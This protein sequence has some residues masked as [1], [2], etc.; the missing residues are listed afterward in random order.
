LVKFPISLAKAL[1]G[2]KASQAKAR[3]AVG[4][5][6]QDHDLVFC[7][8]IGTPINISNLTSRAFKPILDVAGLPSSTRLYDLRHTMATLL[9]EEG[10][11]ARTVAD[12]L[13][14]S[15]VTMTLGTYTHP[16]TAMQ[17]K[18]AERLEDLLFTRRGS[19]TRRR[20]PPP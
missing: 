10:V 18:A 20:S 16:T 1:K 15:S 2:H 11:D 12:R 7:S 17:E 3:L 4:T 14:H 6:W 13:G 5:A 19:A 9:I 8:E